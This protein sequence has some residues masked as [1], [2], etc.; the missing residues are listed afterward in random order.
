MY[1]QLSLAWLLIRISLKEYYVFVC[2][3]LTSKVSKIVFFIYQKINNVWG[4][5]RPENTGAFISIKRVFH[6][7]NPLLIYA[8]LASST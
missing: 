6:F 4:T 8:E 5:S 3:I 7:V 1:D 2:L